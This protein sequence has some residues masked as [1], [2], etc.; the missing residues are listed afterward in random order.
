MLPYISSDRPGV[1]GRADAP[2]AR[3][4]LAEAVAELF[5]GYFALVMATGIISTAA[6]LLGMAAVAWSLLYANVLFY[7]VLWALTIA[8]I[9]AYLPKLLAD[10]AGHARGPGFFTVVAGTCVLGTQLAIVARAE[11]AALALWLLGAALWVFLIYAFFTAVIVREA[12]PAL[13]AGIHGGWLISVVATQSVS[14]LAT[15]LAPAFPAHAQ[16]LLFASLCLCL[17]GGML[18]III[19]SLVFYRLTFFGLP[20]AGLSPLYWITMG[21]AAITTLA[22]ARLILSMG[23]WAFL[24]EIGGFLKGFTLLFWATATWWIPLLVT[25]AVWRHLVKRFPLRYEPQYW[26]MVFP[27]GMYTTCTLVLSRATGLAFL[28][29]IPRVFVW[30]ALAAWAA[31][32]AGMARAILSGA[33]RKE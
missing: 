32:F 12:K 7:V 21:A 29:E 5:P 25:L 26:G 16:A 20:P 19:I 23:Q 11:T 33:R 14:V 2:E 10:L 22:G 27:L 31:V 8:R 30:I 6:S 28:S 18:Y 9:V 15:I 3:S 1:Q 24:A 13:D 4:A 17:A